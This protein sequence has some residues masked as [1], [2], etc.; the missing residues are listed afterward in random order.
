MPHPA[1][2]AAAARRREMVPPPAPQ[3]MAPHAMAPHMT[4]PPSGV[5]Q[6]AYEQ[7]SLPGQACPPQ[8]S[9]MPC[10]SCPDGLPGPTLPGGGFGPPIPSDD[11]W[12]CDGGD[13]PLQVVIGDDWT[14]HGLNIEDTVAHYD[15]LDDGLKIACSNRVCIYAPRFAA[16][17]RVSV[18]LLNAGSERAG[19]FEQRLPPLVERRDL[20]SPTVAQHERLQANRDAL[21]LE[22]FRERRRSA[23]VEND[24][25][26]YENVGQQLPLSAYAL[27]PSGELEGAT[28]A[29][30]AEKTLAAVA[31]TDN[32]AVQV[33]VGEQQAITVT[34]DQ[35]AQAVR[36]VDRPPGRPCVAVTK[37]ASRQHAQPGDEVEFLI[38]YDNFGNEKIGNVTI[39]DNLSPRLEYIPKSQRAE[40]EA[41]FFAEQN[42]AGSLVL[43][44]EIVDPVEPA[45]GGVIRFKCRVR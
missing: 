18:P 45:T 33:S 29:W 40:P 28:A 26:P 38:R 12:V 32:Q 3:F 19:G 10:P 15:T 35:Q 41:Q 24:A 8:A 5:R 6:V 9:G 44:W 13:E 39:L 16:V 20:P 11:E 27:L 2:R 30:L 36:T 22:Q 21:V 37:L 23:G 34:H 7:F 14:V 25:R 1:D 17:R 42:E 31:W 4:A 43:R